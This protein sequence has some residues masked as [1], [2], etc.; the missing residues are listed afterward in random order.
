M[1]AACFAGPEQ[2]PVHRGPPDP[3]AAVSEPGHGERSNSQLLFNVSRYRNKVTFGLAVQVWLLASVL[4]T[5]YIV[6]KS[7]LLT[8]VVS[9]SVL[10]NLID[11][12]V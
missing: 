5:L 3:D 9:K 7:V 8:L 10:L 4:L 6:S 11:T 12:I 2:E 1:E